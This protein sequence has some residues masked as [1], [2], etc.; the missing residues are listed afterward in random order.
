MPDGTRREPSHRHCGWVAERALAWLA[1]FRRL[2]V[3]YE[4]RATIHRALL[5]FGCALIRWRRLCRA[6]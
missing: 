2:T 6:T 5:V 4:R 1:R 3:R